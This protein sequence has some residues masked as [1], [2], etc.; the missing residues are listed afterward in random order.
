M[1]HLILT[2][3]CDSGLTFLLFDMARASLYV[4][5]CWG[6]LGAQIRGGL[7]SFSPPHAHPSIPAELH[8]GGY[9]SAA[10]H[11]SWDLLS[12]IVVVFQAE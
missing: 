7:S 2:G 10:Q 6:D 4:E 12:K 9:D 5:K 1:V 3:K 11:L 8:T